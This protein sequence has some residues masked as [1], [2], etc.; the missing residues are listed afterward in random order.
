[1]AKAKILVI[2]DERIVIDSITKILKEEHIEVEATLSGRQGIE[3]ALQKAY[4]LVLTDLRMPD[5]GGMRVLR[6]IKRA[7]PGVPVVMITGYASVPSAVQAIKLGAA[8]ILEK[9]FSPDGLVAVVRKA[10]GARPGADEADETIHR[11]EIIRLLERAASD[12]NLVY[13]LM[14]CGADA[15]ADYELTNAEKL[16]ILTA[17][18]EWIEKQV[19]QL[20]ATQRKWLDA[21]R[22]N[23]IW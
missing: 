22:T 4:D 7:R 8:D 14:H 5:I 11:G 6:D 19:G 3:M 18:I 15:L 17:D 10:L 20:S 21:R 12:Q 16:A 1:M 23:E 13:E 2:D 9:P